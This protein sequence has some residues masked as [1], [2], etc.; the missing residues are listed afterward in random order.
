MAQTAKDLIDGLVIL[1]K[2]NSGGLD[3]MVVEAYYG[4]IYG[5]PDL[6]QGKV[7]SDD[8]LLLNEAGW[9]LAPCADNWALYP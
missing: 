8:A 9:I 1:S 7:S 6:F 5:C 2:Y 3:S 4:I